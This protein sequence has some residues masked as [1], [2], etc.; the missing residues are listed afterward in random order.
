MY[1]YECSPIDFWHGWHPL[2]TLMVRGGDE[3]DWAMEGLPSPGEV[4]ATW[5]LAQTMARI[6]GWEGDVRSGPYWIPLP[7]DTGVWD[8]AIGWKQDNN[9]TTFI[10]SPVQFTW[11]HR[12]MASRIINDKGEV[13][14]LV[15]RQMANRNGRR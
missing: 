3:Y 14:D 8:F 5:K 2:R 7:W 4:D 1:V 9:G 15:E 11:L 13:I 12:D 10:A 6:L